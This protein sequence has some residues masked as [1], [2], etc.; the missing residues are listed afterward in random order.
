MAEKQ[1]NVMKFSNKMITCST[2]RERNR[3]VCSKHFH[4][5]STVESTSSLWII[6]ITFGCVTMHHNWMLFFC[7][8][9]LSS[10]TQRECGTKHTKTVS[11]IRENMFACYCNIFRHWKQQCE[12]K[13]WCV[14]EDA[15]NVCLWQLA[16]CMQMKEFI[17]NV[18]KLK[19]GN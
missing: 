17:L 10:T 5:E 15:Y 2:L 9:H 19:K 4:S 18:K 12:R 16:M 13:P 1:E 11:S 3:I 6:I 14:Q 8:S 7:L